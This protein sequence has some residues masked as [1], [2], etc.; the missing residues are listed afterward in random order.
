MKASL[1][2][3]SSALVLASGN[4]FAGG[5]TH[6]DVCKAVLALELNHDLGRLRI[7]RG[8]NTPEIVFTHAT[9]RQRSRYRCQF[10]A[11]GKVLWASYL[12]DSKNWG[13]WHDRRED[14]QISWSEQRT[15]LTVKN[16]KG[17]ERVFGTG[18]FRQ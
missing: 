1:L 15:R 7:T 2:L 9:T 16:D 3:L 10:P 12:D 8:G 14:G 4:A 11:E 5:Y 18:D 6:A 17:R 13:R